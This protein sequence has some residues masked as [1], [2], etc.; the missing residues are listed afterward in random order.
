MTDSNG[1]IVTITVNLTV[2]GSGSTS[3]ITWSPNP[4]TLTAAVGGNTASLTVYLTSTTAGT[5]NN[6]TISG[7]GLYVSSVTTTTN[8]TTGYVTC[9]GTPAAF[10]QHLLRQ[11]GGVL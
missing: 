2:N 8:T 1:N 11:L 10:R 7:S 4:V 5:F 6:A 9:T 3:G